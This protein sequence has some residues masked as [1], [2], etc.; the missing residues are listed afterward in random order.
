MSVTCW[1][2]DVR[3]FLDPV[4][5]SCGMSLLPWEERREKAMRYYFEI[6]RC[7]CLGAGLLLVN[8]LRE[9]GV[10]DMKLRYL[11]NGKPVLANEPDV[12][13]NLSHSG[14][15]AV[16]AVS[17]HPVGVDVELLQDMDPGVAGMCFQPVE[18]RWIRDAEDQARAFT[19]LW[20]RKES[21][22]KLAG[23]G[24]S[25]PLTS[26]CVLPGQD[27]A[28]GI[29]YAEKEETGHRICVCTRQR[30]VVIFQQEIF[31]KTEER[32]V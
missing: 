13:F 9:A 10:S 23:D 15:L 12:H 28:N 1:Y 2:C 19:R 20:T 18:R 27:A 7:R 32:A 5:F 11:S 14:N 30:D 17:D 3:V 4:R 21:F 25:R 22:L 31:R 6:D 26:F 24:L 8:A 29:W 16:C